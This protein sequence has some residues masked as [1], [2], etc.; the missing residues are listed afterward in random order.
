[1]RRAEIGRF[2]S[3]S[4]GGELVRAFVPAPLPPHPALA[5]DGPLLQL[6]E[7][8]TLAVGRLDAVS[9]LLPDATLLLSTATAEWGAC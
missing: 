7:A 4:T 1:M 3:T 8:A 5:L 6:L 2:E 9:T